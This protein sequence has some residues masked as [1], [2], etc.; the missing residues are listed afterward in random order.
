LARGFE[1]KSVASQQESAFGELRRDPVPGDAA[2]QERRRG[3]DLT[4]ADLARQLESTTAA[5]RRAA[6][7]SAIRALD[8]ELASLGS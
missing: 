6:L 7:E 8:E 5:P 3:L 1:S 2:K 4:R